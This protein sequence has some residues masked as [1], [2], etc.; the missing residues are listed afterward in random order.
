MTEADEF[1]PGGM[2]DDTS[3]PLADD[4]VICEECGAEVEEAGRDLCDACFD[5]EAVFDE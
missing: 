4:A 2:Y 5:E 3:N 1:A